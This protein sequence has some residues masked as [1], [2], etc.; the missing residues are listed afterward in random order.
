MD[1][2]EARYCGA[3]IAS[4]RTVAG[5]RRRVAG[6]CSTASIAA[7]SG[8]QVFAAPLRG[9]GFAGLCWSFP[10]PK[11][12]RLLGCRQALTLFGCAGHC[13]GVV[14]RVRGA[15]LEC[16]GRHMQQ[17]FRPSFQCVPLR[18]SE[19]SRFT[20]VVVNVTDELWAIMKQLFTAFC[21]LQIGKSSSKGVAYSWRS[22]YE[23]S[24]STCVPAPRGL[25]ASRPLR[26][27]I[28][29]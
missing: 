15:F 22:G 27:A 7:G 18:S 12:G 17:S 16:F 3:G 24:W 9:C 23:W 6:A 11:E 14:E 21:R 29:Q 26:Y 20:G 8:Q 5:R 4:P 2:R 1:G 19:Q 25:P 28:E 13:S 10:R